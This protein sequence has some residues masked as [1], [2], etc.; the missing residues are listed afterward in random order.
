MADRKTVAGRKIESLDTVQNMA[1]GGFWFYLNGKPKHPSI[2]Q[3][4]TLQTVAGF[5][6]RGM[7]RTAESL[8]S[9]TL[10]RTEPDRD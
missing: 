10:Y 6:D 8:E 2:V 3:N 4:M 7:L 5:I 1:A 9:G